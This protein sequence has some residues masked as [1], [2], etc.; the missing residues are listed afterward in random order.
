MTV[1]SLMKF[2]SLSKNKKS[3]GVVRAFIVVVLKLLKKTKKKKRGIKIANL[4]H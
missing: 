3:S 4:K 2:Y 1:I